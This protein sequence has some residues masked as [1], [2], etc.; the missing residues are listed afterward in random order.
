MIFNSRTRQK[1]V[2]TYAPNKFVQLR[3]RRC[4][5]W[6]PMNGCRADA[7]EG[8]EQLALV[9]IVLSTC[10]ETVCTAKGG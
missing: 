4:A 10:L 6:R 3:I 1:E 8:A 9:W 2:A 7:R 5:A